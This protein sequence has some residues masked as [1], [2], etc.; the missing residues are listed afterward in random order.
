M[1]KQALEFSAQ[2]PGYAGRFSAMASPC[3]VLVHSD[4]AKL[5]K[6]ICEAVSQ[7]TWRIEAAFSRYSQ[8]NQIHRINTAKG[9]PIEVNEELAGLLNFADTCWQLSDGAFDISSGVLRRVWL[10]DGGDQLPKDREVNA[11]LPLI[12]WD[13][14]N[15][16]GSSIRLPTGMEIDLGGLGKEYAVDRAARLASQMSDA[17]VL[18]NFG[19][20]LRA[21]RAPWGA[22]AWRVGI[23]NHAGSGAR[24]T[25]E[26]QAGSLATSGDARRYL[27]HEGVRYGHILDPRT[28]WPVEDAAA[29][30]TVARGQCIEAGLM[31]TLALLKGEDAEAFLEEQDCPHWVYR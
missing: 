16:N 17:P 5:A 6:A 13:K 1:K 15:W 18:I 9:K 26:L 27:L 28:G 7:E 8:D 29:S 10:F 24:A 19:G 11:L 23:E 25:V 14:I 12:G 3:E 2:T 22:Q 31:A 4:D 20:D 30:I 21:N